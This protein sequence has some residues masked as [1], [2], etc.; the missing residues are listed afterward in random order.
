VRYFLAATPFEF[1]GIL[2]EESPQQAQQDCRTSARS[3]FDNG[4][5]P[6]RAQLKTDLEF[7]IGLER[8]AIYRSSP[9]L[10]TGE[11]SAITLMPGASQQYL[12]RTTHQPHAALKRGEELLL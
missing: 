7:I 5:Q 3:H 12:R 2:L 4:C 1:P 8:P 10:S 11:Q 9:D 6:S